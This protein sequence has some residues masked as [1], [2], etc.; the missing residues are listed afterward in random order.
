MTR[1]LPVL[2]FIAILAGSA[3]ARAQT[4]PPQTKVGPASPQ[5]QLPAANAYPARPASDVQ[6]IVEPAPGAPGRAVQPVLPP[7]PQQPEWAARMTPDEQKWI[8]DVL[9]YWE[10]TSSKVK[11]FE[12]KFQK[13]DYENGWLDPATGQ[14][15]PRTFAEGAIKYA[16]PDKGL[17]HVEKLVSILPPAQP[18]GDPQQVAQ[19]QELGEHWVCDGQKIYSF[20]AVKKQVTVT[21]LPPGMRGQAIADG[22]LPFMFG[23]RAETIKAR[24]WIHGLPDGPKGKYWL[25]AAPKSRED[26]QNFKSIRIVLDQQDFLPE[27]LQIFAPNYDPPR[28]DAR[29]T[30]LFKERLA[31]DETSVQALIAKNLF[32]VFLREFYEPKIPAGWKKVEQNAAANIP[33]GPEPPP[34]QQAAPPARQNGAVR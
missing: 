20:E 25:E 31:K 3:A 19:A 26:A 18:G 4:K 29:Q 23:A 14:R 1:L 30:Y 13:W 21:P 8:D 17:F 5:I 12:C 2:S 32:G 24:Y 10:T 27:S 16:Q 7:V 28:N 6:P 15:S 34:V 22:P 9:R 33:A 11:A